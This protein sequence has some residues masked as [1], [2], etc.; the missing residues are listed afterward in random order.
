MNLWCNFNMSLSH[1]IFTLC[2]PKAT[3]VFKTVYIILICRQIMVDR[4]PR[5]ST[6][7]TCSVETLL[8]PVD[9]RQL[10]ILCFLSPMN[11]F[12]VWP[13]YFAEN[14]GRH[15]SQILCHRWTNRGLTEYFA[16]NQRRHISQI[17]CHRWTNSWFDRIFCGNPTASHFLNYAMNGKQ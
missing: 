11:K 10:R 14:Q 5:G 7:T 2:I 1:A 12:V 13:E 8:D 17:L 9:S 6:S 16:E 3:I 15:I 4:T